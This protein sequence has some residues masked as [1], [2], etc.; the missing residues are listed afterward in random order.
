MCWIW[1]FSFHRNSLLNLSPQ[2]KAAEFPWQ[3]KTQFIPDNPNN[4]QQFSRV[5]LCTSCGWIGHWLVTQYWVTDCSLSEAL[6]RMFYSAILIILHSQKKLV[7]HD[8]GIQLT[9]NYTLRNKSLNECGYFQSNEFQ[10]K[11]CITVLFC[12]LLVQ[13][14][15]FCKANAANLKRNSVF[16]QSIRRESTL[17]LIQR[18]HFLVTSVTVTI[19]ASMGGLSLLFELLT[20]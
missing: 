14:A 1:M 9:G 16:I 12:P 20:P 6:C 5:S 4:I 13:M 2:M 7:I 18:S 8:S 3:Q 11:K 17:F 15:F 19:I 10:W